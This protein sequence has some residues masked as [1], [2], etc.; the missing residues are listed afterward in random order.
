MIT[1]PCEYKGPKAD[2]KFNAGGLGMLCVCTARDLQQALEQ[3]VSQLR[4]EALDA[5]TSHEAALAQRDTEITK[6]RTKMQEIQHH[7]EVSIAICITMIHTRWWLHTDS[8]CY[9]RHEI[10]YRGAI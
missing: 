9:L 3:Q 2:K 4:Q 5:S 8:W 6:C 7:L 1:L 10:R